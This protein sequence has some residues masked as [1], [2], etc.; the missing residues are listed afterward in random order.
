MSARIIDIHTHLLTVG[1]EP[2]LTELGQ[3]EQLAR[4]NGIARLVLLANVT[5]MGGPNPTPDDII[6]MNT[7]TLAVM[8]HKPQLYIGFCYL[9]PAHPVEF[10]NAE[11]DRCVVRGGMKGI[12]LWIAV[13]CTDTRLDPIMQRA[14]ELGVAVM[15]HAWYKQTAYAYQESTPQE[16]AD[17]A[18]RWPQVTIVM[19]HLSG[20]RER[21]ICD[22]ADLPNV[23]VDTAGSQ[24]DAGLVEYAIG[25][26]GAERV[27][28][29]S[30][31]P[32]RDF[33]VQ[34]GRVVGAG[35]S[36]KEQK[37]IFYENAQRVLGLSEEIS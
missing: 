2:S 21:G 10:I 37:L 22:I 26:L 3:A 27:L 14:A 8:A 1:A 16:I 4:R 13:K 25:R 20:A 6:T 36:D 19:A 5:A 32:L 35:L 12:K 7:H 30:D 31:W 15:H 24:P 11:I 23:L 18:R 28:Y 17:L 33:G 34:V 29:G 9:N